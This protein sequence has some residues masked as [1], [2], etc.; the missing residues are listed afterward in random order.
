MKNRSTGR[1]GRL[2]FNAVHRKRGRHT[3]FP[4][5]VVAS[6]AVTLESRSPGSVVIKKRNTTDPGTLRAAR[7]SR[8]T[9]FY[10][11]KKPSICFGGFTLIELLVVVLI[12]GILAAVALPQYQKA[13]ERT[14]YQQLVVAGS[15]LY[16]AVELYY[17]ANGE[18]PTDW[19][20]LDLS[21][22]EIS[23]Q[24]VQQSAGYSH[25]TQGKDFFCTLRTFV[26]G[27][28]QCMSYIPAGVPQFDIRPGSRSCVARTGD[29][30]AQQICALETGRS[31]RDATAYW[32]YY[33]Y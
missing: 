14:R 33:D 28:I 26:L 8:M 32:L 4:E 1:L 21:V 15:A 11:G 29:T 10:N 3:A 18:Y 17:M 30:R 31:P 20:D 25:V 7:H 6:H 2:F 16:Q 22:G 27:S 24:Y 19:K 5:A 23:G 12:I 13:V 9:S